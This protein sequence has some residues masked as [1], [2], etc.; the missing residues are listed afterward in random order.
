MPA[1]WCQ[2]QPA[3]ARRSPCVDLSSEDS[4]GKDLR[5]IY[6]MLSYK[7][8]T[9]IRCSVM[10]IW[11]YV[12]VCVCVNLCIYKSTQ[13]YSLVMYTK[14]TSSSTH[15]RT[16][17]HTHLLSATWA[18]WEFFCSE[19]L[20]KHHWSPNHIAW[21]M[22]STVTSVPLNKR[23]GQ[24]M[25]A[26]KGYEKS[27]FVT[28][29]HKRHGPVFT[30]MFVGRDVDIPTVWHGFGRDNTHDSNS[31]SLAPAGLLEYNERHDAKL[32]ALCPS[33]QG[34]YGEIDS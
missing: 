34:C 10:S 2:L 16:L 22:Y 8:Y 12:W 3:T 20:E 27:F 14:T 32:W 18:L 1:F 13:F 30:W 24:C 19:T 21:P 6:S 4:N 25:S 17:H 9:L 5:L 23:H 26:Q 11:T 28:K 33:S 15:P 7:S 31:F 29:K